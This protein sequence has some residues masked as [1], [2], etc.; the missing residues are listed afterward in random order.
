MKVLI[1]G[2]PETFGGCAGLKRPVF[3]LTD[4]FVSFPPRPSTLGGCCDLGRPVTVKAFV[5][6][7][8]PPPLPWQPPGLLGVDFCLPLPPP[9]PLPLFGLLPLN[10]LCLFC[11]LHREGKHSDSYGH[12]YYM[13]YHEQGIPSGCVS[14][15]TCHRFSWEGLSEK[16]STKH[17]FVLEDWSSYWGVPQSELA[18]VSGILGR[19]FHGPLPPRSCS[20]T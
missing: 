16:T 19:S 13:W 20:C 6:K 17:W 5:L 1:N 2:S 14:I 18:C 15:R 4:S 9:C 3:I 7:G 8:L 11:G 10:C 12:T